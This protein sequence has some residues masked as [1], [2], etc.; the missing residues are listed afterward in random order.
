M[1]DTTASFRAAAAAFK[2]A[3]VLIALMLVSPHHALA[4]K[5]SSHGGDSGGSGGHSD[6][7]GG[8]GSDDSGSSGS[9]SH[10]ERDGDNNNGDGRAREDRNGNMERSYEGGWRARIKGGRYEVFDPA[11]R[12]VI[13]RKAKSSDYD[14]F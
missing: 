6:S 2:P 4:D 11:G 7:D 1:V 12:M 5:G 8:H 9:S 13:R 14:T 10:G 3:A